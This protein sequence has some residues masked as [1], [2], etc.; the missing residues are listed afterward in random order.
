VSSMN[1]MCEG[2]SLDDEVYVCR[3]YNNHHTK[4]ILGIKCYTNLLTIVIQLVRVSLEV[5]LEP[6][7]E[8]EVTFV[9]LRIL[10]CLEYF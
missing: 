2:L 6:V 10:S 3:L 1:F 4:M 8:A 5:T 7:L 9:T